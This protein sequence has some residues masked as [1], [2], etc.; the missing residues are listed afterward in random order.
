MIAIS[1]LMVLSHS[2]IKFVFLIMLPSCFFL[3]F[4]EWKENKIKGGEGDVKSFSTDKIP[5]AENKFNR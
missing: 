4:T 2:E 3:D 1:A 5:M